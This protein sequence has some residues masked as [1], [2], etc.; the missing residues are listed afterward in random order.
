[1]KKGE[2]SF[3]FKIASIKKTWKGNKAEHPKK[4]VGKTIVLNLKKIS[5]HHGKKIWA[6]YKAM[7]NGDRI[8]LE[9]F[10]LGDETLS[11]KEWLKKIEVDEP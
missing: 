10:D 11:I 9:A 1:M 8:E 4:A 5:E 2:A 6:N 3:S 7:K